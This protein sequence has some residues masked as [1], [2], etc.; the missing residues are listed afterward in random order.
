MTCPLCSSPNARIVSQEHTRDP[1]TGA[2]DGGERLVC[3]CGTWEADE[4][5]RILAE[6]EAK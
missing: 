1:D 2:V 4:V 6:R 3:E 5:D